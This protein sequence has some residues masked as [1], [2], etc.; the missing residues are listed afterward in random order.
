MSSA[1]RPA[2]S[3]FSFIG[4]NIRLLRKQRGWTIASLAAAASMAEV[5][6]G[7]IERGENAP[8]AGVLYR[9]AKVFGVSV[10]TLFAEGEDILVSRQAASTEDPFIPVR[11]AEAFSQTIAQTTREIITAVC[12][13]EDICRAQK[14]AA[15]PL[16]LNFEA[17]ERGLRDLAETVRH[18]MGIGTSIVFDYIELFESIGFRV[19]F[20]PLPKDKPSISFYDMNNRNAFFF[21]RNRMNPE[22]QLFQLVYGLGRVLMLS[23]TE[24]HGRRPFPTGR[25]KTP[26]AEEQPQAAAAA[27]PAAGASETLEGKPLTM[28]RAARKFAAFFLMPEQAV[29]ATV[30]QLGIRDDEWSWELL[31]RLKHRFGVSADAF[32]FRL[33]EL[34]LI[35]LILHERFRE[36]IHDHYQ[37]TDFAEPDASRRVITPNG[38]IWDLVLAARQRRDAAPELKK[39]EA[40]LTRWKVVKV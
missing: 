40:T 9:L 39:I 17:G 22:R 25:E 34:G 31:L 26:P 4:R 1:P 3:D 15:I 10:D 30:N 27:A 6:L 37:A 11:P 8:S 7:R 35:D 33:R 24:Q 38:R 20:L 21:I 5:P 36:R 16:N 2:K 19:V 18:Y 14:Q 13:L 23:W 28:H 32:L 29:R 12:M